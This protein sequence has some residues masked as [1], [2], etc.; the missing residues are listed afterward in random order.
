MT[1]LTLSG[2]GAMT[3]LLCLL[4]AVFLLAS[5]GRLALA[6]RYLAGF[7][8]LTAIDLSGLMG[9][10]APVDMQA[11]LA[12]R[13]PLSFLQMPLFYAYLVL[14]CRPSI[15]MRMHGAGALMLAGLAFVDMALRSGGQLPDWATAALHIQFYIYLALSALAA[16]RLERAVR[17]NRSSPQTA[18]LIWMWAVIGTSFFAHS[19]VAFRSLSAALGWPVPLLGVQMVITFIALV[20]LCAMTMTALLKPSLFRP[21]TPEEARPS[22]PPR[23]TPDMAALAQRLEAHMAREQSYLDPSLTLKGLARRLS[24]GERELSTTL[25]HQLGLHFFD[26]VNQ[27]RIRHAQALILEDQARSGTLL[28]IAYASGFNSKS[29]FNTAFRKHAGQTPSAFRASAENDDA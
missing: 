3:S 11:F 10:L 19:L 27:C 24:V 14:L 28:D 13:A 7:L 5:G 20:I 4:L 22:E 12:W 18:Q 29:S 23:L 25:N 6:N 15:D 26:Y 2:L 8:I 16:W 17:T 1:A 21:M 9:L